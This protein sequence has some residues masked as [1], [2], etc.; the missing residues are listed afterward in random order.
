MKNRRYMP[1]MTGMLFLILL[2]C[3]GMTA[4]AAPSVTGDTDLSVTKDG[5]VSA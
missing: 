5:N 1:G 3:F 4:M 2:L